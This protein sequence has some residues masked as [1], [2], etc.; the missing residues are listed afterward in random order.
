MIDELFLNRVERSLDVK[1]HELQSYLTLLNSATFAG[2]AVF[3]K[4]E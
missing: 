3:M 4:H 2:C 1:G